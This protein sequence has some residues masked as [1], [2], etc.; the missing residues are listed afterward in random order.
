MKLLKASEL[1]QLQD[2]KVFRHSKWI[3]LVLPLFMGGI[4]GGFA[5][6]AYKASSVIL[7]IFAALMWLLFYV[8]LDSIGSAWSERN[9]L[10][11]VSP[12]QFVIQFRSYLN[13]HFSNDE[14]I[15]VLLSRSDIVSVGCARESISVPGAE[16]KERYVQNYSFL[17]LRLEPSIVPAIA[18]A[19]KTERDRIAPKIGRSRMKYSH[20]PVF[21]V[22]PD[23][24]RLTWRGRSD[25]IFPSIKKALEL[26]KEQKISLHDEPAPVFTQ[27]NTESEL[28][29]KLVFLCESGDK[30]TAIKI[31]RKHFGMDLT[32][33]KKYVENLR[34]G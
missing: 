7:G 5:F 30:I 14:P 27:S 32:E 3:A 6:A 22:E 2:E 31:A 9:W 15:A 17:D 4:A 13:R 18:Q 8:M 24:L 26:L 12:N 28:R 10:L 25:F 11:R 19:L 1:P 21:L 33:A 23:L 34:N 20:N 16:V 29:S